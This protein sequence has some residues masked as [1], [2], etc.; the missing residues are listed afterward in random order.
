MSWHL[1]GEGLG[2]SAARVKDLWFWAL[3]IHGLGF[4]SLYPR[5]HT[6]F[7]VQVVLV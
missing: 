1:G 6:K 4:P 3:G 2:F 5:Y 7:K